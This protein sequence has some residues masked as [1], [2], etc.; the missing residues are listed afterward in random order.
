MRWRK[1]GMCGVVVR[2]KHS[3]VEDNTL[4]H[5]DRSNSIVSSSSSSLSFSC[6]GERRRR[7]GSITGRA[8]GIN[9]SSSSSSS[10]LVGNLSLLST[11]TI[12]STTSPAYSPRSARGQINKRR[13]AFVR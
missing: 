3:F 5:H 13:N 10:I 9:S 11:I 7:R 12:S 1:G 2:S 8:C 6:S 4:I